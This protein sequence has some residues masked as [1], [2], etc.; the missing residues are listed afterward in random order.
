MSDREPDLCVRLPGIFPPH[1]E[2][3]LSFP[4]RDIVGRFVAI[5]ICKKDQPPSNSSVLAYTMSNFAGLFFS[6]SLPSLFH[7][8]KA[9]FVHF[10]HPKN[11]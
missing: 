2:K 8:H 9:G 7:F 1:V 11:A 6:T 4:R 5:S 3:S 10:K